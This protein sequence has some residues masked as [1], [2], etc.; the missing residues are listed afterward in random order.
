MQK[1]KWKNTRRNNMTMIM[2]HKIM[3]KEKE[4]KNKK[5]HRDN[6]NRKFRV[7]GDIGP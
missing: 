1:R 7:N 2:A 3:G 5:T 4:H 6:F